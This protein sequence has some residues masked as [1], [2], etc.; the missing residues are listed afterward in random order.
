MLKTSLIA[1]ARHELGHALEAP[2]GR[3]AKTVVGGHERRLRQTVMALRAGEALSEHENPGEAT[4][5]VLTGR[6][7]LRF[8]DAS[9]NGSV[10]DLLTVPDG[11]HSLEA[12]EDS[13]ILFTVVK[14]L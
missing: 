12:V 5:Q 11:L 6:V 13:V 10:G 8:A 1:L 7:L 14:R 2:S 3:S 9:W 4:V